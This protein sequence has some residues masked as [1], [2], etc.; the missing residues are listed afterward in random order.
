MKKNNYFLVARNRDT[1]T[2]KIL[3][4]YGERGSQLEKIDYATSKFK[5]SDELR[6]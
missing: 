1:N 2:F 6:S 3:R 5:S 4:V